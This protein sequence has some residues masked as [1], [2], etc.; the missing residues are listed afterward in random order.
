MTD[1]QR[2]LRGSF[3]RQRGVASVVQSRAALTEVLAPPDDLDIDARREWEWHMV[4]AVAAGTI[5]PT[6]LTAFRGLCETAAL[7]RKAYRRALKEAPIAVGDRGSKANPVWVAFNA[8]DTAYRQWLA[9][10]GLTPKAGAGLPQLPVP[11]ATKLEA[12]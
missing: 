6:N 4:Q 10:F 7:R 3:R 2:R 12:V 11:G 9:A 5:A 1:Q 8:V